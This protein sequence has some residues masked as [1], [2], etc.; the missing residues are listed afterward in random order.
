MKSQN[1]SKT[2]KEKQRQGGCHAFRCSNKDTEDESLVNY[3]KQLLGNL[4]AIE[5]EAQAEVEVY[6][7][8][9]ICKDREEGNIT[10]N[11][12]NDEEVKKAEEFSLKEGC[13][14]NIRITFK[15]HNDIVFGLKF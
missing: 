1:P 7:I 15:V 6:S 5:E 9:F 12:K 10:L 3:K 11:F 13:V 2:Q 4:D 14:F 8:E